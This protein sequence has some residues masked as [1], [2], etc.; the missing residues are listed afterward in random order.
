MT[1]DFILQ[2]RATL[3]VEGRKLIVESDKLYDEGRKLHAEGRK[4]H[5]KGYN[6]Y[7]EGY[8]LLDEGDKLYAEGDKLYDESDKLFVEGRKLLDYYLKGTKYELV[9]FGGFEI[10]LIDG[11]GTYTGVELWHTRELEPSC[12]K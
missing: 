9:D 10:L 2:K 11:R 12:A 1:L 6:L 5:D 7:A 3:F 4:L 8:K